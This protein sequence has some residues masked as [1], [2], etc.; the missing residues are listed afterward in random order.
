[1]REA[2]DTESFKVHKEIACF[3][4]PVLKAAF[5]SPFIEGQTQTYILNNVTQEAVQLLVDWLYFQNIDL[6]QLDTKPGDENT[7]I[8]AMVQLWVLADRLLIP[9]LQNLL[10]RELDKWHVK[11]RKIC[12]SAFNFLYENSASDCPLRLFF[13]HQVVCSASYKI[14]LLSP[15]RYP[16]QMLLE[17]V[18]LQQKHARSE[19]ILQARTGY[20]TNWRQYE[21]AEP[22]VPGASSHTGNLSWMLQKNL[23]IICS[24]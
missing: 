5:E 15:S 7:K 8:E 23:L 22:D 10:I 11:E 9:T 18:T 3:Y 12:D 17:I 16:K 13:V 1:M 21:V 14:F 20:E 6:E 2:P 19:S 24:S 4:S